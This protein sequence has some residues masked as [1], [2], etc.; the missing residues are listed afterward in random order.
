[1]LLIKIKI[2]G[3][4]RF[5]DPT[6]I[7]FDG[8]LIALVGPNEAGKSTILEAVE[9]VGDTGPISIQERTRA[10][11]PSAGSTAIEALWLLEDADLEAISVPQGSDRP[12]WFVERKTFGGTIR[13]QLIP[14]LLRDRRPRERLL[15]QLDKALDSK[16]LKALD[17]DDG[18]E[19][20]LVRVKKLR[21]EIAVAGETLSPDTIAT[22]RWLA[23]QLDEGI[24]EAPKYVQDL[25][26]Q[27]RAA[28]DHEEAE[29]PD[30][31][32]RD[33]LND[34][35]PAF[36]RFDLAEREL[37]STYDLTEVADDP[38][39]ALANLAAL[40]G[41]DLRKLRDEI[42]L[43]D[44][45]IAIE[46]LEA[47]NAQLKQRIAEAWGQSDVEPRFDNDDYVLR[48]FVRTGKGGLQDIAQRSEGLRAFVALVAFT[49]ER[50]RRVAPILLIDEAD[51]HL[52]YDAQAD[53]IQ[54]LSRQQQAAQV[55][56]TTHSAGCLPQDLGTGV[57]L[58]EPNEDQERSS[59]ENWPWQK[60]QGFGPLLLGMGA[61][62]LAFV[63]TRAAL[64]GEGG[65]EVVLLPT[66]MRQAVGLRTL[67]FQVASGA[68]EASRATTAHIDFQGSKVAWLVDGDT[69]GADNRRH[70]RSSNI[71][72]ERIFT[73]G[74]EGSG[75]TTEDLVQADVFVDAANEELRRSHG[76]DAARLVSGHVPS[77]GRW[78]SLEKWCEAAGLAVPN[79]GAVAHRIAAQRSERT[80]V[81]D[82]RVETLRALHTALAQVFSS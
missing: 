37:D 1:M 49:T 79:K 33:V 32:A 5:K 54:M 25:I 10:T 13:S 3:Y 19:L 34:L 20:T 65:S 44:R 31:T 8:K 39:R 46:R 74:G 66:L 30:D 22:V 17:A 76:E 23:T 41:L 52:H 62:T 2:A 78:R 82:G 64:I 26:G 47:A 7:N 51:I 36:L 9:R 28:A 69:G 35:T 14:A 12:R 38:P 59:V 42:S 70:L 40:A 71:P 6:T 48:L 81:A 50:A 72:S 21:E 77:P 60:D 61:S 45:G 4:R 67:D 68:A 15:K 63:P 11:T 16:P 29:H 43:A 18:N 73:L 75:L 80:L 55:I 53:L 24:D 58:V 57:R 27:L 56:Y